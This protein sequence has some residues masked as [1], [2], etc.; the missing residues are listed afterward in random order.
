VRAKKVGLI[1]WRKFHMR[2]RNDTVFDA[3]ETRDWHDFFSSA[4][5]IQ[6][7]STSM[8][9]FSYFNS[10]AFETITHDFCI[11]IKTIIGT[12]TK[13]FC[14]DYKVVNLLRCVYQPYSTPAEGSQCCWIVYAGALA[15]K[16]RHQCGL[17]RFQGIKPCSE[18]RQFQG[19]LATGPINS[20]NL[21]EKDC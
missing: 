9:A 17:S 11:M 4:W 2:T 8:A 6:I 20:A 3:E 15:K 16:M 12:L 10:V 5:T 14:V 1:F 13:R 19:L 21:A 18:I 7:D